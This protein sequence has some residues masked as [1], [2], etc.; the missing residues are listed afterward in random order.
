M[1]SCKGNSPVPAPGELP[2]QLTIRS[3]YW[4]F[5]PLQDLMFVLLTPLAIVLAFA[6]AR[7]GGWV[8]GLI[9]FGL[10]LAMAHYLPGILRGYGDTA[11]F[12]R[13]RLRLI[14]APVF[15]FSITA[16]FAYLNLH[17]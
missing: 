11:L 1:V 6:A 8:D 4:I 10:A 17:I 9:T 12:R 14:V 7:R 16:L 13:F 5:S 15:L 3:S 2:L